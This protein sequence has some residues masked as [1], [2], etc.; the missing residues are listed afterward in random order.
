M[1][2]FNKKGDSLSLN[3][4]I[5]AALALIVLVILVMIFT[6]R[7]SI[8]KLGVDKAGETELAKLKLN[9]GVCHPTSSK[10]S[11]FLDSLSKAS[12]E[13]AKSTEISTFSSEISRCKAY[14]TDKTTCEG[15]GCSWQ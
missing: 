12:S 3:V 10:E 9:Y 4:I 14:N 15:A 1:S 8:F 5:V 2:F 13:T 6:G 7:I 11:S